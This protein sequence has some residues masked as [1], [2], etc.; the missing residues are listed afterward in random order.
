M[1]RKGTRISEG[2]R[3]KVRGEGASWERKESGERKHKTQRHPPPGSRW[4]K[5]RFEGLG[6]RMSLAKGSPE[7][8]EGKHRCQRDGGLILGRSPEGPRG[9]DALSAPRKGRGRRRGESEGRS[10]TAGAR[11]A[12]AKPDRGKRWPW[13]KGCGTRGRTGQ[14]RGRRAWGG[15]GG[16]GLDNCRGDERAGRRRAAEGCQNA[17]GQGGEAGGRR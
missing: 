13:G 11:R 7:R 4:L 16:T 5:C 10:T 12:T 9:W 8:G 1:E 3:C 2:G 17:A 15:V 6:W 14:N